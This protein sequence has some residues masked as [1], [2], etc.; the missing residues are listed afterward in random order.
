MKEKILFSSLVIITTII[1]SSILLNIYLTT[2][3]AHS[4]NN[5]E[6]TYF[7]STN[8][9]KLFSERTI[10][11]SQKSFKLL[12]KWKIEISKEIKEKAISIAKNDSDVQ[13]LLDE[14]YNITN[15]RPIIKAVTK[16]DN[17]VA[18]KVIGVIIT[19]K[20]NSTNYAFIKV[21]LEKTKVT[22]IVILTKTVIKKP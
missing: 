7:V 12:R 1:I 2:V 17:N 15:V 11:N 13:K 21:D 18:I 10:T 16:K 4:V 9:T 20:K 6:N 8:F 22:E 19:L 5:E 3:N 14:G